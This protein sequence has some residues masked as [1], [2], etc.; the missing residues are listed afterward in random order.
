[1]ALFLNTSDSIGLI[2]TAGTQNLTGDIVATL[3]MI[4]AILLSI[5]ILFGIPFEFT[6]IILFPLLLTMA[7]WY[8]AFWV[9]IVGLIL[10]F[11]IIVAKNFIFR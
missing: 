6:I 4:L 5:S 9:V 10:Y 2:I 1:M 11:G 8:S 3:F 7:A